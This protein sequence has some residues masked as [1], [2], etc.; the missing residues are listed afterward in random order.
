MLRTVRARLALT[1]S[2]TVFLIIIASGQSRRN[3]TISA[4]TARENS[5]HGI[6]PLLSSSVDVASTL[7][8]TPAEPE[9]ESSGPYR[10]DDGEVTFSYVT[11]NQAKIYH[12]PQSMVGK[13]FTIYF[14]P[15]PPLKPADSI[16]VRRFRKCVDRLDP[17]Y[18]Y[19]VSHDRGL[20]YQIKKATSEIEVVIY[21]PVEEQIL[22]LK[23][24]T[25]CV[26]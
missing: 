25:T 23:V 14:R 12:A 20:A 15:N 3:R 2:L 18:Y 6:T 24:D 9:A 5:W 22:K 11:P 10:I 26:F 8:V 13:V 7:S 4:A 19:L 1:L 21:Q 16:D 17:R